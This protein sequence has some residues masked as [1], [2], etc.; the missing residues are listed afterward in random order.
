MS[1]DEIRIK[2]IRV[3]Q[4]LLARGYK[5][6]QV[7]GIITKN[8]DYLAPGMQKVKSEKKNTKYSMNYISSGIRFNGN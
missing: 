4:N 7:F 6:T 1:F 2:S 3:A 8:Y 5:P